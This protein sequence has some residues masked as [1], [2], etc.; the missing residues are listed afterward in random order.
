[1][2]SR[3]TV[4]K[5]SSI[6]RNNLPIIES[7]KMKCVIFDIEIDKYCSTTETVLVWLSILKHQTSGSTKGVSLGQG[8]WFVQQWRT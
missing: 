2:K 3:M 8:S 7:I 4:T 1:M 6:L 5:S